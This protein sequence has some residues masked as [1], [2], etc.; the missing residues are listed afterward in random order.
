MTSSVRQYQFQPG[1][2]AMMPVSA[3]L[4][5]GKPVF[6]A[7]EVARALGY[8]NPSKA[9]N[10]HCKSLIKL[11]YNE[12]LESGFGINPRGAML[13][14]QADVFRL[15]MR[16]K[17]PSA[18]R[19]QDWVCEEV[20]PQIMA[21]GQFA[22]PDFTD[23][24]VAAKA[25]IAEREKSQALALQ[26]Q[27]LTERVEQLESLFTDGMTA[28]QF[29]KLL[30]GVNVQQVNAFLCSAGWLFNESSR[31]HRW[32]VASAARDRYM[33]EQVRDYQVNG[34]EQRGHVPVL[35]R[36]GALWLYRKYQLEKLPMKAS[37][38]GR[39]THDKSLQVVNAAA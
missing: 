13:I 15:V 37:W 30:N 33:T 32:R 3:S 5:N 14:G 21:T 1:D 2:G 18:E 39:L 26:A 10:D 17:L 4:H 29:C 8:S 25:W 22:L 12:S 27:Q 35:L 34:V 36:A 28:V 20:L 6:M 7:V 9:L 38:D 24:I 19:F 31:G 23:P 11:D 16:S